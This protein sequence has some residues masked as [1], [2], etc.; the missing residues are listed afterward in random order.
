MAGLTIQ[1][2]AHAEEGTGAPVAGELVS[3]EPKPAAPPTSGREDYDQLVSFNAMEPGEPYFLGKGHD[4]EIEP[5]VR[6]YAMRIHKAGVDVALVESAL[7]LADKIGRWEPEKPKTK[8]L[9]NTSH[10]TVQQLQQLRYRFS[11][12]AHRAAEDNVDPRIML[13]QERARSEI[14][15][16]LG[17]ILRRL[18][19]GGTWTG[20][21]KFVFDRASLDRSDEQMPPLPCPVEDL[22]AYMVTVGREL[23]ADEP[24]N[25]AL[26]ILADLI[27]LRRLKAQDGAT[28]SYLAAREAAWARAEALVTEAGA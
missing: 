8:R 22:R 12:R 7:Q 13:A 3:A 26:K 11:L 20:D 2:V 14:F 10:L 16:R 24:R 9:P 28:P 1:D 21:G 25:R 19:N 4:Q 27:D 6:Y 17:P 18:F 5:T 23:A 15:S